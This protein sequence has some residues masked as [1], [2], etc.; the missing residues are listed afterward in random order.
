MHE[1]IHSKPSLP[2]DGGIAHVPGNSKPDENCVPYGCRVS[3][4]EVRGSKTPY[5]PERTFAASVC[6]GGKI[7]S[8]T[9]FGFSHSRRKEHGP[10][11]IQPAPG[12]VPLL[13][14]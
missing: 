11:S 4:G 5:R 2:G 9:T 13:P 6:A 14:Q 10:D 3:H 1:P 7:Q 12:E 8:G